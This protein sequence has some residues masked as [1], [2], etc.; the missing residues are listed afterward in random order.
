MKL[1]DWLPKFN[2]RQ[3]TVRNLLIAMALLML[4]WWVND[5]LAPTPSLALRWKAEEYALAKPELLYRSEKAQNGRNIIFRSGEFYGATVEY[6]HGWLGYRMSDVFLTQ[7]EA[8]IALLPEMDRFRGDELYVYN[9]SPE[10]VRADC[11]LRMRHDVNVN[12]VHFDWDET[13]F[14]EA[15]PNEN[16]LYRFKIPRKYGDEGI[17]SAR[18]AAEESV[19]DSCLRAVEWGYSDIDACYDIAITF[20]DTQGREVHT[21]EKTIEHARPT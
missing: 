14:M 5:F 13:Y 11:E 8:G 9:E 4:G 20:Y 1:C 3:K 19:I 17:I 21:Y 7:A 10:A 15:C 12:A 16:G 6:R 18:N 2:R